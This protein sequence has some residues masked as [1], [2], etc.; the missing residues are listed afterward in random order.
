MR[1]LTKSHK[2]ESCRG[3][4]IMLKLTHKRPTETIHVRDLRNGEVVCGQDVSWHPSTVNVQERIDVKQPNNEDGSAGNVGSAVA[5]T[6][7][8]ISKKTGQQQ[9]QQQLRQKLQPQLEQQR[10]QRQQQQHPQA[11]RALGQLT[12]HFTGQQPP[13][14]AKR[15]RG[16][17][18]SSN[19]NSACLVL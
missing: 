10:Q 6:F 19:E 13:I 14:G 3:Q 18:S 9:P 4:C 5:V 17:Y 7:G 15:V 1:T 2:L 11:S 12:D 16:G 8:T